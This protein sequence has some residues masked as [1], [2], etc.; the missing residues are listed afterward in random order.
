LVQAHGCG[1]GVDQAMELRDSAG[2]SM[3]P[4]GHLGGVVHHDG[5]L[6]VRLAVDAAVDAEHDRV[7][8][9]VES[10]RGLCRD[11]ARAF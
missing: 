10:L 11:A 8:L 7:V 4:A 5:E 1:E 2:R 3:G 9:A 6:F